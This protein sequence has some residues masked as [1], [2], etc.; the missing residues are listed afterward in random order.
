MILALA[1]QRAAARLAMGCPV[2]ASAALRLPFAPSAWATPHNCLMTERGREG[3]DILGG[4]GGIRGRSPPAAWR[5]GP[6]ARRRIVGEHG[7]APKI[8]AFAS[9]MRFA[10]DFVSEVPDA[11]EV[12]NKSK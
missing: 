2:L 8:F 9:A 4:G 12:E 11:H 10:E 7:V 1:D 5:E 3:R 6:R